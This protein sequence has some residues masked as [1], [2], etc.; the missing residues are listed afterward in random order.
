MAQGHG[1]HRPNVRKHTS[2]SAS[3]MLTNE[4]ALHHAMSASLQ[5][6]VLLFQHSATQLRK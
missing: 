3:Q 2:S 6:S 5:C 1:Q 4:S